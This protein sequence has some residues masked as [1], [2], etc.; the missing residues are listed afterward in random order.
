[1]AEW[2]KAPD[3]STS[4]AWFETRTD[5]AF[6]SPMEAGVRIPLLSPSIDTQYGKW[7]IEIEAVDLDFSRTIDFINLERDLIYSVKV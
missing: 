3:S 6:W 7:I 1:M 4:G 5:W 2:S